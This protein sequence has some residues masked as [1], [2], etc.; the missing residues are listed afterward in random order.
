MALQNRGF[1]AV[2]VFGADGCKDRIADAVDAMAILA[3]CSKASIEGDQRVLC[4]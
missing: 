4:D 1:E 2:A 3:R